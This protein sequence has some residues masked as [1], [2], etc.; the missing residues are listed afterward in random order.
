MV[1]DRHDWI[2]REDAVET[3]PRGPSAGLRMRVPS[4][5][6]DAGQCRPDRRSARTTASG[7]RHAGP[8]CLHAVDPGRCA[9]HRG[10]A[11]RGEDPFT[12]RRST[13]RRMPPLRN[14]SRRT[15][16]SSTRDTRLLADPTLPIP[17]ELRA[18][19]LKGYRALASGDPAAKAQAVQALLALHEEPAG[20]CGREAAR[21]SRREP[22]RFPDREPDR[23]DAG[24]SGPIAVLGSKPAR[25][26]WTIRASRR[27][28]R[29][30]GS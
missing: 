15:R 26:P 21:R 1:L 17:A 7:Q 6:V 25:Q 16:P 12:M 27:S 19:L 23:D 10:E 13:L 9:G 30:S 11:R 20:G 24:I 4:I 29:N 22:R 14:G 3:R 8:V 28:P 2:G 18:A 5:R